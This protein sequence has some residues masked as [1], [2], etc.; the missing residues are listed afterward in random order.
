MAGIDNL[1]KKYTHQISSFFIA[2]LFIA[3]SRK[4]NR[5]CCLGVWAAL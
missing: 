5:C 1:K 3:S 4:W 2:L